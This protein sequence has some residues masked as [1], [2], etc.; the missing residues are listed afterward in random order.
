[1]NA[2]MTKA[3]H[4]QGIVTPEGIGIHNAIRRHF[5]FNNRSSVFVFALGI[6]AMRPLHD[7]AIQQPIFSFAFFE[8]YRSKTTIL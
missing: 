2:L 3:A 4:I 1:M 8:D 7:T 5:L 6:N